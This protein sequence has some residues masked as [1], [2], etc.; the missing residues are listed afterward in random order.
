MSIRGNAASAAIA[1]LLALALLL[2][3]SPVRAAAAGGGGIVSHKLKGGGSSS[4]HSGF[5]RAQIR[6]AKPL[7]LPALDARAAR[8]AAAAAAAEPT[9]K[10]GYIEGRPPA[11]LGTAASAGGP[12]A[13]GFGKFT[14]KAVAD[15]TVFPNTTNGKVIGKI[16]GVGLYSCSASVVH[17]KNRN[18]IFTA[19][20]CV[21]EPGGHFASRLEFA[22]AYSDGSAPLGAWSADK[23]FIQ[24]AWAQGNTNYDY[25]A[26]AMKPSQGRKL[27]KLTGSKL[28]LIH[29]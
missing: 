27:E 12:S 10:P 9:G 20:H 8:S 11:G 21:K 15:P 2:S 28:S 16:K 26:V 3:L 1:G 29:I 7:P 13:R 24:N 5:S 18:T 14:S 23:I 25:A 22:P 6:R 19:G 17:A 4:S